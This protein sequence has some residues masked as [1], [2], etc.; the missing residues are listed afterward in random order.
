MLT[1][2]WK[3]VPFG[4]TGEVMCICEKGSELVD[5]WSCG[6]GEGGDVIGAGVCG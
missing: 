6:K 1:Y 5:V 4:Y 3:S 2:G